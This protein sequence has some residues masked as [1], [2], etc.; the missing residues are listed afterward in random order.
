M[1]KRT[2]KEYEAL[3]QKHMA[4]LQCSR[5]EA[6]DLI[7]CDDEIDKGNTDLFALSDEQKK[8]VRQVTKA[9]R[10]PEAKRTV[11]RERKIDEDKAHVFDILRIPLEGFALNGEIQ[12]LTC[13]N[14]AEI[15]FTYN[16]A[17]YTVKLTKHRAKKA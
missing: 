15:S 8:I 17:D 14:E 4:T 11:K 1:A 16:G 9:D 12:N 5:D 13:K 7:A 2:Q 10:D 6:I 3:I